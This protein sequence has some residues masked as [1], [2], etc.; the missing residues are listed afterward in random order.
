ML[1]EIKDVRQNPGEGFRRWF[2]DQEFDL[3]VFYP[4]DEMAE[5]SGF[6][7]CYRRNG[8]EK[9]LTWYRHRGYQ[10]SSVDEGEVPYRGKMSPILVRDGVFDPEP[11]LTG[12]LG[13]AEKVDSGIVTQV[14]ERLNNLQF[15]LE[16]IGG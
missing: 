6:Q 14:E 7:L 12:F 3:I 5:I 1:N 11:V 16:K 8:D 2:R 4:D 15:S 9:V 13:A 10:H